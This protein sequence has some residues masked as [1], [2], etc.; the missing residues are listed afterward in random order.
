MID[1]VYVVDSVDVEAAIEVVRWTNV[2]NLIA[3]EDV[4]DVLV[5]D[6]V[7]VSHMGQVV[8]NFFGAA[9]G[10]PIWLVDEHDSAVEV[11]ILTRDINAAFVLGENAVPCG[12]ADRIAKVHLD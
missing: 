1:L 4:Y 11:V 10:V 6:K 8:N 9:I 2:L 7:L 12:G 5:Y 3:E